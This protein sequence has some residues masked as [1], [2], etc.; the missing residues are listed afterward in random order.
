MP[1]YNNFTTVNIR[2]YLNTQDDADIGENMLHQILSDFSCPANTDV[3]RFLKEQS[4]EFTR[5]NQSVTYLVISNEDAELLGYF[6]LAV[7]P[8]TVSTHDFSNTLKRKY[9]GLPNGMKK[10][11]HIVYQH[12]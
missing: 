8:I 4:I 7:K 10:A 1:K 6:T 2:E 11:I 12:I 9:Q 5:K 3:E